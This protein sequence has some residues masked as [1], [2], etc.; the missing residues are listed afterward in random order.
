MLRQA[1]ILDA[2]LRKD[3]KIWVGILPYRKELLIFAS[4]GRGVAIHRVGARQAEMCDGD[5]GCNDI[6]TIMIEGLPEF[7]RCQ[8]R[9]AGLQV[10]FPAFDQNVE[11]DSL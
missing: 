2:S 5:F 4:A 7:R 10:S 1:G 11:T 6:D 9:L 3:R 8:L